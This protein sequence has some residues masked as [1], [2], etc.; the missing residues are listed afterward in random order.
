[1]PKNQ[2]LSAPGKLRVSAFAATLKKVLFTARHTAPPSSQ[3]A[4]GGFRL[5]ALEPRM[6][7]SGS[8]MAVA[9]T[10]LA[11]TDIASEAQNDRLRHAA[12]SVVLGFEHLD[13]GTAAGSGPHIVIG[14][15]IAISP[16]IHGAATA[17]SPIIGSSGAAT[18][19]GT[20][21]DAGLR[22]TP[23]ADVGGDRRSEALPH[24]GQLIFVDAALAGD[25]ALIATLRQQAAAS[26]GLEIVV[27]DASTD[28]LSQ[29]GTVLESR[30]NL[31]AVHILSHGSAASLELGNAVLD[32]TSLPAR[33]AELSI[34]AQSFAPGGDILLYG[35][36]VADGEWGLAFVDSLATLTGL[37]L[38]A[39]A[40]ATGAAAL[41]GNWV[42]EASRGVIEADSLAVAAYAGLLLTTGTT[43]PD[44]LTSTSAN[45]NLEGFAGDD[46]YVFSTPFGQDK[47]IEKP[48]QGTDTL[49][50]RTIATPTV[51]KLNG[52]GKL[53]NI[54]SGTNA[55]TGANGG[56][57]ADIEEVLGGAELTLDASTVTG[58]LKITIN[59]GSVD[60]ADA[61]GVKVLGVKA[62]KHIQ[63]GAGGAIVAFAS[64]GSIG[65]KISVTGAGTLDYSGYGAPIAVDL[66]KGAATGVAGGVSGIKAVIGSQRGGTVV[67]GN[68]AGS[69]TGG[70]GVDRLT[71]NGGNDILS[72]GGGDDVLVGNDGDDTL[73]GGAGNDTL[74]GGAGNDVLNGGDGT[75]T[76]NSGPGT[77]TLIGGAGND[78]Y[79]F[80]ALD[81]DG[82]KT[83]TEAASGG[84]DT[85]QLGA[86]ALDIQVDLSD[87]FTLTKT[88]E[89][90]LVFTETVRHVE[91]IELSQGKT[92]VKVA[93]TW[94]RTD[95]NL[96][97]AVTATPSEISLDLSAVT[98]TLVFRFRLDG[99]G[100]NELSVDRVD[101]NGKR[102][103]TLTVV[104]TVKQLTAGAGENAFVFEGAGTAPAEL[105]LSSGDN[106]FDYSARDGSV[107]LT[108][109]LEAPQ[110]AA[111]SPPASTIRL[112]SAPAVT[113]AP[114]HVRD[115][116][117]TGSASH[118]NTVE[119]FVNA[120]GG[121]K[122]DI[123]TGSDAADQLSGGEGK[124]TLKGEGGNDRL[125]GG[126]GNDHLYGGVGDD[127]LNGGAGKDHLY[128]G[129]GNDLLDGG[130]GDDEFLLDSEALGDYDR[131]VGGTGSD[132]YNLFKDK[133]WGIASIQEVKSGPHGTRYGDQDTIDL[134]DLQADRV[135]ILNDG[136]LFSTSDA[137][138]VASLP[139]INVGLTG[140]R[141]SPGSVH[142]E[143]GLS[144]YQSAS[145]TGET[146]TLK[147][148]GLLSA[149]GLT[150]DLSFRLM[151]DR[152]DGVA[153]IHDLTMA[154][155]SDY[156]TDLTPLNNQLTGTGVTAVRVGRA[157]DPSSLLDKHLG[158]TVTRKAGATGEIRIELVLQS[159]HTVV[160]E[161]ERIETL[162]LGK[163]NQTL[164][165]GNAYRGDRYDVATLAQALP[166]VDTI[167]R[168]LQD[169]LTIDASVMTTG[170][171]LVLDFRAVNH[172]LRFNFS[173]TSDPHKVN[174][175][176]TTVRDLTMPLYDLGPT[177]QDQEIVITGLDENA[178]VYGGRFKNTFNFDAGTTFKGT[179]VGGEGGAFGGAY[180][181]PGRL[182]DN[183]LALAGM[184]ES[185]VNYDAGA[186][187]DL[188]FEVE[189]VL[190]YSNFNPLADGEFS[191]N[192]LVTYV[193]LQ[194]LSG[195]TGNDAK[196]AALA[197]NLWGPLIDEL[198]GARSTTGL[199]TD[200][201]KATKAAVGDVIVRSG[202]NV[203]R[204]T[205]RPL[206]GS[207]KDLS[208]PNDK[209]TLEEAALAL[210]ENE[211]ADTISIGDN[212]LSVTPGIHILAGGSGADTYRVRSQFWGL[213][214]MLDDLYRVDVDLGTIGNPVLDTILPQDTA[215]FS[216]VYQDLYF[217]A[218]TL[219][220]KDVEAIRERYAGIA[221]IG[222]G[223]IEVG[224][225][226]VLT[227]GFNPFGVTSD[228]EALT[229][230][231]VFTR[232]DAA[233]IGQGNVAISVGVE[234]FV[235][236]RGKNTF[237]FYDGGEFGGRIGPGPGGSM[238]LDYAQL[239]GPLSQWSTGVKVD[240]AAAHT[241]YTVIPSFEKSLPPWAASLGAAVTVQFGSATNV[242]GGRLGVAGGAAVIGSPLDDEIV[243]DESE[244]DFKGGA[245]NDRIDGRGGDDKIEGGAGD[246][247]LIGGDGGD[248]LSAGD[249]NDRVYGGPG[250]DTY[251]PDT[252]VERLHVLYDGA[253]LPAAHA[254]AT[255]AETDTVFDVETTLLA[256]T[257]LPQAAVFVTG[258][259]GHAFKFD[260]ESMHQPEGQTHAFTFHLKDGDRLDFSQYGLD[261]VHFGTYEAG[262]DSVASSQILTVTRAAGAD[263]AR[264][265]LKIT[266]R[267]FRELWAADFV[268]SGTS[269]LGAGAAGGQAVAVGAPQLEAL[270]ERA[271]QQWLAEVTTD[272][273]ASAQSTLQGLSISLI[274]LPGAALAQTAG[275]TIAIDPTAAGQGWYV[276]AEADQAT[277]FVSD[278]PGVWRAVAGGAADGRQDLLTALL[279]EMGHALGYQSDEARHA[280]TDGSLMADTLATGRRLA[281]TAADAALLTGTPVS[282]ALQTALSDQQKLLDGLEAFA[283]RAQTF[284][285]LDVGGVELPFIQTAI[286]T[287]WKTS[288]AGDAIR[289]GIRSEILALF[290]GK[291]QVTRAD[292][293][294]LPSVRAGQGADFQATIDLATTSTDLNLNAASLGLLSSLGID[295]KLFGTITQSTALELE[296]T[297]SLDFGFGLDSRSEDFYIQ[298]PTLRAGLRL[299]HDQPLD[300]AMRL[301]PIELAVAGGR[302]DLDV[303]VIAPTSG[304]HGVADLDQLT[305]GKLRLDRTSHYELNLPIEVR[306][307][308]VG[309][310][311]TIGTLSGSFNQDG[312]SAG[313]LDKLGGIREFASL[314]S[315]TLEFKGPGLGAL[316]DLSR[317][318][319]DDALAALK[320]GLQGAFDP[321]GAAYQ[322]LPFIDQSL[323]ELLGN[324]SVDLVQQIVSVIDDV[325]RKLTTIDRAEI[326]LNQRLNEVL[327]LGLP[328][329]SGVELAHQQ[330]AALSQDLGAHSSAGDLE[331]ALARRDHGGALDALRID[332]DVTA[333]SALLAAAGLSPRATDL[334]IARSLAP[335]QQVQELS[336]ASTHFAAA[337]VDLRTGWTRL[338]SHGFDHRTTDEEIRARFDRSELEEQALAQRAIAVDP[339]ALAADRLAATRALAGIGL[340]ATSAEAV[341]RATLA[342]T[343]LIERAQTDR[344]RAA[345]AD[346]A[347]LA[348]AQT[349]R[350]GGFDAAASELAIVTALAPP[351]RLA[352][353]RAL[354]DLVV[355]SQLDPAAAAA[356]LTARGLN[357]ASS[358]AD[359]I[360]ALADRAQLARYQ[361]HVQTLASYDSNKLVGLSY[362]DSMLAVDFAFSKV[363]QHDLALNLSAADVP[364][365][366]DLLGSAVTIDL[367]SPDD[368]KLRVTA[369][370]GI[371]LHLA[372]DLRDLGAPSVLA[373]D[374]SAA[375]F[376][377][378]ADTVDRN[379][380]LAPIDV[381]M[382][383]G[384]NGLLA[385][386]K[387]EK[388]HVHLELAGGVRLRPAETGN[389][390]A[391]SEVG[392][393]WQAGAV[394][395]VVADLPLS[396]AGGPLGST[397][398]GNRDGIPD[399]VLHIDGRIDGLQQQLRVV[400]PDVTS[401]FN[402]TALLND[403]AL[404]L[405]GLEA[406]FDGL[407]DQV[408][409]RVDG[410]V[411]P[412]IGK[413]MEGASNFVDELKHSLLGKADAAGRYVDAA[414][415]PM[416]TLGG[417]LQARIDRNEG[418]LE[419]ILETVAEALYTRLGSLL[420]V[421]QRNDAGDKVFDSKG[422]AIHVRPTSAKDLA[423]SF[424]SDGF[425][426]DLRLDGSVFGG[427]K[428]VPLDFA[429][430]FPGF[431]LTSTA[432][433]DV[434]LRYQLGLGFGFDAKAG[435]YL[436]TAGINPAGEDLLLSLEVSIPDH[437]H[438]AAQLGFLTASLTSLADADGASRLSGRFSI[439]LQAGP[440][441]RWSLS[442]QEAL[443]V[444]ARFNADANVDLGAEIKVAGD[445]ISLPRISTTL[446]YDQVFA[447]IEL[448]SGKTGGTDFSSGAIIRLEDVKLDVGQAISGFVGPLVNQIKAVLDP[449]EPVLG[450]LT[451]PIDLGVTQFRLLDLARLGLSGSQ[452]ALVEAALNAIQSTI[453][454][455][456]LVGDFDGR[457]VIVGFGDF[458]LNGQA[459]TNGTDVKL[460]S[461]VVVSKSIAL[462]R[463][464]PGFSAITQRF[465]TTKGAFQFPILQDP[466]TVLGLLTGR[467]VDLFLYDMPQLGLDFTYQLSKPVFPGL[468]ARF[469][470]GIKAST[471]FG[472]GFDTVGLSTWAKTY[473]FAPEDIGVILDGFFVDDHFDGTKDLPEVTLTAGITAG[474]SLGVGGLVEA[475]VQGGVEGIV[476]LD[477]NDPNRD[478]KLRAD[479][480]LGYLQDDPLCL[481]DSQGQLSAFLEAFL[482]IGLD[483]G[484]FG[485]I[486]FFE[487]RERFVDA[488]LASFDHS[489]PPTAPPKIAQLD[490]GNLTLL[491][492]GAANH[493]VDMVRAGGTDAN[494]QPT[495]VI[496]A[497]AATHVQ[498]RSG[499]TAAQFAIGDV[500]RITAKGSVQADNYSIGAGFSA[501]DIE[502]LSGG[503][504]DRI[505][506]SSGHH[507]TVKAGAPDAATSDPAQP[508]DNDE[509][510]I[511]AAVTGNIHVETGRG[512]DRI[513]IKSDAQ[514]PTNYSGSVLD[515]GEGADEIIGGDRKDTIIGGSASD[516][517]LGRGGDDTIHAGDALGDSSSSSDV[518]H[519]DGGDGNDTI[520][521]SRGVD[522]IH[523]SAGNDIISGGAG[524]D[525]LFG[526]DGD[527]TIYGESEGFETEV[528]GEEYRDTIEG[529][530]GNDRLHGNAGSDLFIWSAGDGE[531]WID[532]G[533]AGKAADQSDGRPA[534]KA[535]DQLIVRGGAGRTEDSF[536]VVRS[537]LAGYDVRVGHAGAGSQG[538][539]QVRSVST[540]RIEAGEGAD[541]IDI[542]DLTG[543]AVKRVDV[544]AGRGEL[545]DRRRALDLAQLHERTVTTT[546]VAADTVLP[547]AAEQRFVYRR[548]VLAAG[549]GSYL[550]DEVTGA[551][552]LDETG[553]QKVNGETTGLFEFVESR[554]IT[555]HAVVSIEVSEPDATEKPQTIETFHRHRLVG[556]EHL[557]E[558]G[559]PVLRLETVDGTSRWM[560]QVSA[561]AEL[562]LQDGRAVLDEVQLHRTSVSVIASVEAVFDASTKPDPAFSVKQG[563]LR[564]QLQAGGLYLFNQDGTPD[565]VYDAELQRLVQQH[566]GSVVAGSDLREVETRELLS[567]HVERVAVVETVNG[568]AVLD[569]NG[570][571][572]IKKGPDGQEVYDIFI[573]PRFGR[574]SQV[575]V[576]TIKGSA[577]SDHFDVSTELH[578]GLQ[579]DVVKVRHQG[580]IELSIENSTADDDQLIIR[581]FADGDDQT[582]ESSDADT[583]VTVGGTD[584]AKDQ[585]TPAIGTD[586]L[587]TL[588]IE[589]GSGDDRLRVSSYVDVAES[590]LGNDEITV[591][592][593]VAQHAGNLRIGSGAGNDR[594]EVLAVSGALIVSTGDGADAVDVRAS[595]AGS[596][597]S[598]QAGD[599]DDLISLSGSAAVG[600]VG[601]IDRILGRVEI[602]GAG[603]VDVLHVDDSRS[604]AAKAGTLGADHLAG[605]GLSG[606]VSYRNLEDFNLRLGSG[607]DVLYVDGTH[608]GTTQVHA[609]SGQG[610]AGSRDDRIAIRSTGGV[611]TVHAGGG[612]D[613][614]EVNVRATTLPQDASRALL[615]SAAG[616]FV[617]THGNGVGA[618]LDLH[619]E[620]GSDRVTLNLAGSGA[621]EI[622]VFDRGAPDDGV[623][624][625]IVNGADTVAGISNRPDDVFVLRRNLVALRNGPLEGG[626]PEQVERVN[627]DSGIDGGLFVNSL[628]GDDRIV[629]DDTSTRTTIDAG[630]GNDTVQIGQI[631]GTPRDAQAGVAPGDGFD[632][633]PVIIGK[634]TDP[635]SGEV[636]FNPT[637]FDPVAD[638]LAPQV[639]EDIRAAIAHQSRLGLALDGIA[640]V[641]NGVSFG[642]T[643]RGG[644]GNDTFNVYRNL[645]SLR[646]EGEDGNDEFVVRAFVSI[647]TSGPAGKQAVTDVSGGKGDDTIQYAINA[648]VNIDGGAGFDTV[649][650]L[651][652]PFN[653]RFVVTSTGVYGAGLNVGFS[654][655]ESVE[656]DALEGSDNIDIIG[657]GAGMVTRVIGG[658]GSDSIRVL[659]DVEGPVISSNP[660]IGLGRTLQ[661]L[662]AIR[663]PLIVEGGIGAGVDRS[664][665]DPVMLPGET[666]HPSRQI[667]PEPDEPSDIDTLSIF[668]ADSARADAGLLAYRTFDE[669]GVALANPGLSLRGFEMGDD[670]PIDEGTVTAPRLVTYGGGITL[671]GF[672]I[673]E[674]LLGAGNERLTVNDT[675]DRDE[676]AGLPVDHATITLIHGGGGSDTI[677]INGRGNGPLV[678]YG[679]TSD[680]GARYNPLFPAHAHNL[681][682]AG[683]DTID[684]SGLKAGNDPYAGVVIHGGP[685]DDL[686]T[687]SQGNDQLAGGAGRDTI[688]GEGGDDHIYGDA[689][690]NVDPLLFARDLRNP[691]ASDPAGLRSVEAM[692]SVRLTPTPDADTLSGGAGN[693]IIL[694]DQGVIGLTL[695]ARR[696]H[697]QLPVE[698]I[699]TV[700][701]SAGGADRLSGDAGDDILL[702]GHGGDTIDGGDGSD[703]ILGD[704]GV[705]D[706]MALDGDRTTLD[707]IQSTS[708]ALGGGADTIR[709][710]AGNDMVIGGRF[711]DTIDA[712]DG[713]DIVLGDSGRLVA[714]RE[715]GISP[716]AAHGFSIGLITPDQ[717]SD[718]GND[719]IQGGAGN[720]LIIGS[721]GHDDIDG[722]DGADLI[723]GDQAFISVTSGVFDSRAFP[724]LHGSPIRHTFI[725]DD[726]GRWSGNDSLRGG[727]GDDLLFGQEGNDQLFGD[728]GDDDLIGGLGSDKLYGGGGDDILL[729]GLGQVLRT[730][731]GAGRVRRSEVLLLDQVVLAGSIALDDPALPFGDRAT[732]DA[733]LGSDITLL[734]GT[735]RADGTRSTVVDAL[736][737]PQWDTRAL[738][739]NL[740][741]DGNDLLDGGDGDDSLFGQMG[742]DVLRGGAGRDLLVGGTGHDDLDGG[743]GDDLLVGDDALIDSRD[744]TFV[745]ITHGYL[746]VPAAA[747]RHAALGIELPADGQ[748]IVPMLETV[749][750]RGMEAV[751]G[752]LPHL[753]GQA[754]A[755]P[756]DNLLRTADGLRL[757]PHVSLITDFVH[758]PDLLHGND[759]LRGQAGRDTLIGDDLIVSAPVVHFDAAAAR[760]AEF[761]TRTVH[762]LSGAWADLV[763]RQYALVGGAWSDKGRSE[764]TLVIDRLLV[765]GEDVLDGGEG[766]DVLI[767]D[768]AR[769]IAPHFQVD[770]GAMAAFELF[771]Q[772]MQTAGDELVASTQD[773]MR[774][775]HM[776]RDRP[777]RVATKVGGVKYLDRTEH[778]VDAISLGNDVIRGAGGNDLIIGDEQLTRTPLVTISIGAG[779]VELD[780]RHWLD[781][782][783][784]FERGSRA[785][786][787]K[788][789]GWKGSDKHF[790]LDM[791]FVNADDI[792]AGAGN[793]LVWG[794]G[795]ATLGST[796]RP[797]AG[798]SDQDPRY[799]Q[800]AKAVAS[801]QQTLEIVVSETEQYLEY[802]RHGHD[803]QKYWRDFRWA[804]KADAAWIAARARATDGGDKILGGSGNDVLYGQEGIDTI[805]GG[806]GDDWL[807]GGHG[808]AKPRDSLSG[809]GGFDRIDSGHNDDR[810]LV[811]AV[812]RALPTW[813]GAFAGTGLHAEPV[814]RRQPGREGTQGR[815]HRSAVVH[816]HARDRQQ[817]LADEWRRLGG[818]PGGT[819]RTDEPAR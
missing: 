795:I 671:N 390:I 717:L 685:G 784:W 486:T 26:D 227:T 217:T 572:V 787:W 399:N 13:A 794:D 501:V 567:S 666:N 796:V 388:A 782:L 488:V 615:D 729:G 609:G 457:S 587:K 812:E 262:S 606:G 136:G 86:L 68:Q 444:V 504:S 114:D 38:A 514:N 650:V 27:L 495:W 418:S 344:N 539:V 684:A 213:A 734:A 228:P 32:R 236:G 765:I 341:I 799:K 670:L 566:E 384:W 655:V 674:I 243:G 78:T 131:L 770:H 797:V 716:W 31:A 45:E 489:C 537:A 764:D 773:L 9:S 182:T 579:A 271:R 293:L 462:P 681:G 448:V 187:R 251:L 63:V 70:A 601:H 575:D 745:N 603:G 667:L 107:A 434:E 189:N 157:D 538:S 353:L 785:D 775:E 268:V 593:N 134:S 389:A 313:L 594:V 582:R 162:K 89:P 153:T 415:M 753:F 657:T 358:D 470:A 179:L 506:I 352:P 132:T 747:S 49:D 5:E 249:G 480:L 29:I 777:I 287:L 266:V 97:A 66:T 441:G 307:G 11:A 547:A 225:T 735:H 258:A 345:A 693:D 599:G 695:G 511:S 754:A 57:I 431:A 649:V 819:G 793:D 641:S 394:G 220:L 60:I 312:R 119:A 776:L 141:P 259:A 74:N 473:A 523:G 637:G 235:G 557:F 324:G 423:A 809:G 629:V 177:L 767:G 645:A 728:A 186:L 430:A 632:T 639:L 778:H 588:R 705:L 403:P 739:L 88:T 47:V 788:A 336:Q 503:G 682:V 404:I 340:S 61:S 763:H 550:F 40:D 741:R 281:V 133:P 276:G 44:V 758:H 612:D 327:G 306:G 497:A 465:G 171:K 515:G 244:N 71:G 375:G 818:Q 192:D 216:G 19:I 676:K 234:N 223:G 546:V 711:G 229:L 335:A 732:L 577:R 383:L 690:F 87:G 476:T 725:N 461:D 343:A 4:P 378:N 184:A 730:P 512:R 817:R 3:P 90:V 270:A 64:G 783:Q 414:G 571:P 421:Q 433:L 398:D 169:R 84:R 542:D 28:G 662:R 25:A 564:A 215:D 440:D 517:I 173:R 14:A 463:N 534:G 456:K 509:V 302:I 354:R 412:L 238:V 191:R 122:D 755:I 591:H 696:L 521:G 30:R 772:G 583:V 610:A 532:G 125:D 479:E 617:R 502:I 298:A 285:K 751:A 46:R 178:E 329:G 196:T 164:L 450:L 166:V 581:T 563:F 402:L 172:E 23:A 128:G 342:G 559:L 496:D 516:K 702:G 484:I 254:S 180:T 226:I 1:M 99:N 37:D 91:T 22:P 203:V 407:R 710:G 643:V 449:I 282:G 721:A 468:N 625:L 781:L 664:F 771:V 510:V 299:H 296:A 376:S 377:L 321:N 20:E 199:S 529:G 363:Y 183:A 540:I 16:G 288:G 361:A 349:L 283:A 278:S 553:V 522:V 454:F 464:D 769:E 295:E 505:V 252:S 305:L 204:G 706:W 303:G 263:H 738:L 311:A 231:N 619:G 10:A 597:L 478:G 309:L 802:S 598:I 535:A 800:A 211:G 595:D 635:L 543:T 369:Q 170:N 350:A 241:E 168:L 622:N 79:A 524:S 455:A 644:D 624:S 467:D 627:F 364:A 426:F 135:T 481:F 422:Q 165:F 368:G 530:R 111:A 691:L 367:K 279:H 569:A 176:V 42:L 286:D 570:K 148:S 318:S 219:G 224:T 277:D 424:G 379:G 103:A 656:L 85:I 100:K 680:D 786:W 308:P 393:H 146:V 748:V 417:Y 620:G 400:T 792:D 351:E 65:G 240:L 95:L 435:F 197:G 372:I 214:L 565:L 439:D 499:K 195:Q 558:Q 160:A 304:R 548:P 718:G 301:G 673:V 339:A 337:G 207:V 142:T 233:N 174:L 297:V 654:G 761:V 552:S 62:L 198:A 221:E 803:H 104:G 212:L 471:H 101:A 804:S 323:V 709:G 630:A 117:I 432:S 420:Q 507:V 56:P 520:I 631:F 669:R 712:G 726:A 138:L 810:Q 687:G 614:I 419:S 743:D 633:T 736:G 698:R 371:D 222:L 483:T 366:V 447:D 442:Q 525:L 260:F 2:T 541:R 127:E 703:I 109:K 482:W 33:A 704:E 80:A 53:Q 642:T 82:K 744:A 374:H 408:A 416:D 715:S 590:G 526:D 648:P 528:E 290:E 604:S 675:G 255:G 621:A 527:D 261:G 437:S 158:F 679:D 392:Q 653:D 43:G 798:L 72:G 205:D 265:A 628:G 319:L 15:P 475:G 723:F 768:D 159:D 83:I 185:L 385:T 634:I 474:A 264:L 151:V 689:A 586:L 317:I 722:G 98:G 52:A 699:E 616:W 316:S 652:T 355:A 677:I 348:A 347:F 665:S 459:L 39:S 36:N 147:A 246:D 370:A 618:R 67:D 256:G 130:A 742:N 623:D 494:G 790:Q 661:D 436:D 121:E 466:S 733:L 678:V 816:R 700:G 118:G 58:L 382:T 766:D 686:I 140:S 801:A 640:Y 446:H 17:D 194:K 206:Y 720:D 6:L 143:V 273:Y 427:P 659:G 737:Q 48:D 668:H 284:L 380:Q 239:D 406:M 752:V 492:T 636:L 701:A 646:L 167:A 274:D 491:S 237:T 386:I 445:A 188:W 193:N 651:G 746:V 322:R 774:L 453:E 760:A 330:L 320:T 124:D 592:G 291:S 102:L 247:T 562:A 149:V 73:A 280:K 451:K 92:V 584:I 24:A 346:Q 808:E 757:A 391:L 116:R 607:A 533:P 647:D 779:P 688:K 163:G 275:L 600:G 452:F 574:D 707:L 568:K 727:A 314:L 218:F 724:L 152:G 93:D 81:L 401:T 129:A 18:L 477:L 362:A 626:G 356:R 508:E 123:L 485:T 310:S 331:L 762:H 94:T 719:R 458:V 805:N 250:D 338:L 34:W 144:H 55:I 334:E 232:A 405:R 360:T 536:A 365:L 126:A 697:R 289:S 395:T 692:F 328:I 811:A 672:E 554:S 791:I 410:V 555:S 413:A 41:G 69:L 519:I 611:T 242:G 576:I 561:N 580:G 589:T 76:L 498:V 7:L 181:F 493:R 267:G 113:G 490:A 605:F 806:S 658:V 740:Q 300:V 429:A 814:R 549:G 269:A 257:S 750:G 110:A 663:G 292:L 387:A 120:S 411:L 209:V 500:S 472:F 608:A 200:P 551:P 357:G 381:A 325:Q 115:V 150:A 373:Y 294:A 428:S 708:M 12:D 59:A 660:L 208:S 759:T 154:M 105:V 210:L 253:A 409:D 96:H 201:T 397:A 714:T 556:G 443:T 713:M 106:H 108:W 245:G 54:T 332:R 425:T 487:A 815:R 359:I 202:I 638:T 145:G 544:D 613:V 75:D 155:G 518:N 585:T 77:D 190:S 35:C 560:Q 21:H 749:P 578:K 460:G 602:D 50:L 596:F 531:D 731:D 513:E 156:T 789:W 139:S 315:N 333:A 807:I 396:F 272:R 683:N 438:L 175:T 230:S 51:L 248:T 326:E 112:P 545:L 469:E 694:G 137:I 8:S 813:A 756:V 780:A 573:Q 161:S